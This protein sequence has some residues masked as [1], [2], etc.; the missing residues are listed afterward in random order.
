M[1][2]QCHSGLIF[3]HTKAKEETVAV[4]RFLF[5]SSVEVEV[6]LKIHA[7]AAGILAKMTLCTAFITHYY[8]WKAV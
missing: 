8:F 4:D 1:V 7:H 5:N 6:A 2:L 3:S